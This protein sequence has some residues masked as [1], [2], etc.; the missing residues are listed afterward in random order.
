V[1]NLLLKSTIIGV[2]LLYAPLAVMAPG[3]V[4][5][6]PHL[7]LGRR[8]ALVL[9][10]AVAIAGCDLTGQYEANFQKAIQE[11]QRRAVFD[12]SLHQAFTEVIDPA[13]EVKLRI[14]KAFDD[15]SKWLKADDPRAKV[16]FAELPGLATVL[17]RLLDNQSQEYAY[18]YFAAAPK[19][20]QKAEALQN[21]LARQ[22]A[23]ALPGATWSDVQLLKPDGQSLT[24]RRLRVDG[25]QPFFN[26]KK[27]A[28]A[29]VDGRFDLYYL[30][31]GGRHVLIAWRYPKALGEK[32]QLDPA[33][34]AAMGTVEITPSAAP[35]PKGKKAAE[36]TADS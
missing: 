12:L 34:E 2:V 19:G 28:M 13:R 36:A 8:I 30:D 1:F 31:G 22:I 29:K 3:T 20:D 23:A 5:S 35:P 14:P 25:Q 15:K 11:S 17:E 10:L 21:E 6:T 27:K 26:P 9:L 24:L 32:Y 33:T 4:Q 7:T 16:P 18:L